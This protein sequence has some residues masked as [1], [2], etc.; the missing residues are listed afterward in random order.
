MLK[1]INVAVSVQGENGEAEEVHRK[2]SEGTHLVGDEKLGRVLQGYHYHIH[3]QHA[4]QNKEWFVRSYEETRRVRGG[5][6]FWS[7]ILRYNCECNRGDRRSCADGREVKI[8]KAKS[9]GIYQDVIR[10]SCESIINN[11]SL[12]T[13]LNIN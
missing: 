4:M 7:L 1:L 6:R 2:R 13:I 3:Y 9:A 10:D 11:T 12:P 5:F 8:G